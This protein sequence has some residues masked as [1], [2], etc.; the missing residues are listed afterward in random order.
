MF[1][2]VPQPW[3]R[4]VNPN[5]ECPTCPGPKSVRCWW[6]RVWASWMK[7]LRKRLPSWSDDCGGRDKAGSFMW[8]D[9]M[10]PKQSDMPWKLKRSLDIGHI[11]SFRLFKDLLSKGLLV[12]WLWDLESQSPKFETEQ[13]LSAEEAWTCN[14]F[15]TIVFTVRSWRWALMVSTTSNYCFEVVKCTPIFAIVWLGT[16]A[17]ACQGRITKASS[18]PDWRSWTK[19]QKPLGLRQAKCFASS[20]A[21]YA[22]PE[23]IGLIC[24][25]D[26]SMMNSK[27]SLQK[28]FQNAIRDCPINESG[29][30]CRSPV[31][32][33]AKAVLKSNWSHLY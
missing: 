12:C 24:V 32:N 2:W 30:T 3:P 27:P 10:P 8:P 21:N 14:C 9:E 18:R 26:P 28:V 16:N 11:V 13:T 1:Y 4:G 23:S 20:S 7:R 5:S 6:L 22:P 31:L 25:C 15:E 19:R 17:L 29:K 33:T